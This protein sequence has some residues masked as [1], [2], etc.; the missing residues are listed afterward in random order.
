[1]LRWYFFECPNKA[2][3]ELLFEL[4]VGDCADKVR[5]NKVGT[6]EA[7]GLHEFKELVEE[8]GWLE[9]P[10]VQLHSVGVEFG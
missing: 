7:H 6:F 10:L 2:L 3:V 4:V 1:M 9:L 8:L 5:E